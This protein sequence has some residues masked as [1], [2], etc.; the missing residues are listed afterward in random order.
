MADQWLQG[1]LIATIVASILTLGSKLTYA[2]KGDAKDLH[3]RMN[4]SDEIREGLKNSYLQKADHEIICNGNTARLELH[5]SKEIKNMK[6][7]ILHA[8]ESNGK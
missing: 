7:E 4:K 1:G 5:V 8:I 2:T 3:K 6:E